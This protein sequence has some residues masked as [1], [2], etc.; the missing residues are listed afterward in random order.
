MLLIP[1]HAGAEHLFLLKSP[2]K[3]DGCSGIHGNQSVWP[4]LT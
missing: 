4:K 3:K 1:T 2:C